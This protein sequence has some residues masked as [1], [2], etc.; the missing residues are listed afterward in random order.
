VVPRLLPGDQQVVHG[1]LNASRG[2][3][4]IAW[5]H[6]RAK[7]R[8]RAFLKVAQTFLSVQFEQ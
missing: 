6:G 7:T 3:L 2:G 8:C 4:K 5:F 1:F